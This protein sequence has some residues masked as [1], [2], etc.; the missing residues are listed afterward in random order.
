MS[1]RLIV[2]NIDSE[3]A[4]LAIS[5]P[6]DI[7][8][9]QGFSHVNR[10]C[11]ALAWRAIVRRELGTEVVISYDEYGAPCVNIPDVSIGVSHSRGVVAVIFSATR[12][13]VDIEHKDR[14]FRKVAERYL[15]PSEQAL[16]EQYDLYAEIWCAK[17]AL[18]KYYRRGALDLVKDIKI[19]AYRLADSVIEA[20]ICDGERIEVRLARSGDLVI[21]TIG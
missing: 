11:E 14:D 13:A 15:S 10:R 18:Y 8:I 7:A 16:A 19:G 9:A 3:G 12:C 2:E 6:E 17:E 5:H 4:L 20:T 1:S 21:A